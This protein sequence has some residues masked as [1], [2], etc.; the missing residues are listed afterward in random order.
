MSLAYRSLVLVLT[1]TILDTSLNLAL[2]QDEVIQSSNKTPHSK[3]LITNVNI[4][5]MAGKGPNILNN[6]SVL[7]EENKIVQISASS[8]LASVEDATIVKGQGRFLLPGLIDAHVHVWD[9]AELAA[10]LAFGVTTVRNAS[11]MPFH[12]TFSKEIEA[13]NMEGPRL[14]TTGPILNGQGPNT[15]VNHQIVSSA[16]DAREAVQQQYKKGYRHLKVYSNL[17]REAY[18]AILSESR[19]LGMTIMGH[20]PEG[21]R[22]PGIPYTKPFNI[23]FSEVLDD[24]FVSI[25]HMESIV[26]HALYDELSEK[27]VR[28]LATHIARSATAITPTL[29]AHHNLVL[30]AQSQG[31]YLKRSD[32]EFLN[33]F[34]SE[35]EKDSYELWSN[36]LPL[37]RREFDEFY[38]RATKIF[39]EEGVTLL[40]GTDSGIFTNIPGLSL[41]EELKLLVQ[42][43]LTPYQALQTATTNPA[44]VLG[45]EEQLGK[46][47]LGY[48]ADLVLVNGNPTKDILK[49]RSLSGLSVRGVWYDENE[50]SRLKHKAANTYYE[51]TERRVREGLKAQGTL[52]D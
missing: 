51:R 30:V 29:L 24:G 14:I 19:K 34:I 21:T 39:Q 3:L 25:E 11:G 7:I 28:L 43:G 32:I 16:K 38:L 52:L 46:V 36:Q 31:E 37:A 40:A 42:A 20:T 12:L 49:L 45:L 41:I 8:E 9:E 2:A 6:Y 47:E 27:K 15:Q 26:W 44:K 48:A 22:E 4:L 23:A 1:L 5:T 18:E 33:P 10:Y 13:G 50:I 17:S 35:F